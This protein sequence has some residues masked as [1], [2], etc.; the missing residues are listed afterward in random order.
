MMTMQSIF[1]GSAIALGVRIQ[2]SQTRTTPTC[3]WKG[4]NK[5]KKQESVR[6]NGRARILLG[7]YLNELR[8]YYQFNPPRSNED[9]TNSDESEGFHSICTPSPIDPSELIILRAL[10]EHFIIDFKEK[11]KKRHG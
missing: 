6:K 3:N 2:A 8:D 5:P 10:T 4:K 9:Y 11:T 1:P 7:R